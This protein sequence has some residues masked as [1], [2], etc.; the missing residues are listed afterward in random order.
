MKCLDIEC[1]VSNYFNPRVN[2]CIP[3]V[4]WSF[5]HYEADL[6]VLTKSAY[7]YEIEIKVSKADLKKDLDKRHR[8]DHR[9]ISKV[10]FAI[11][12]GLLKH[13]DLIP[14]YAG[15][16]VADESWFCRKER[17]APKRHHYKLSD[18][19]VTSLYRLGAL[20]L[21]TAKRKLKETIDSHRRCCEV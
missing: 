1:A 11:P 18:Q 9:K 8:H 5:L 14:E 15:I 3:N 6:L 19:E 4:S 12:E 13:S 2:L 16:L 10:Y 17:E 20:K 21:W 7:L